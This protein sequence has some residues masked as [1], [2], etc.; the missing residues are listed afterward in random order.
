MEKLLLLKYFI[1][2]D[3]K[4]TYNTFKNESKTELLPKNLEQLI[5]DFPS[6]SLDNFE[7][8]LQNYELSDVLYPKVVK[9]LFLFFIVKTKLANNNPKKLNSKLL[10]LRQFIHGKY[11]ALLLEFHAELPVFSESVKKNFFKNKADWLSEDLLKRRFVQKLVKAHFRDSILA[12]LGMKDLFYLRKVF[13]QNTDCLVTRRKHSEIDK[14]ISSLTPTPI[15]EEVGC[16]TGFEGDVD[17]VLFE[18]QTEKLFVC[19][20]WTGV[21]VFSFAA[22]LQHLRSGG[23]SDINELVHSNK[24]VQFYWSAFDSTDFEL[25]CQAYNVSGN[26]D[27]LQVFTEP[28]FDKKMKEFKTQRNSQNTFVVPYILGKRHDFVLSKVSERAN[29]LG[30][31]TQDRELFVLFK[32]RKESGYFPALRK[33]YVENFCFYGENVLLLLTLQGDVLQ[34]HLETGKFWKVFANRKNA[35]AVMDFDSERNE[36]ILLERTGLLEIWEVGEVPD[37]WKLLFKR[38]VKAHQSD[39][40]LINARFHKVD[41]Q[42]LLLMNTGTTYSENFSLDSKQ[43]QDT[44]LL[45]W[46]VDSTTVVGEFRGHRQELFI[47]HST[48]DTEGKLVFCG[49]EDS[50]LFVWS[51]GSK[52]PVLI[53]E[54]HVGV[55]NACETFTFNKTRFLATV[56]DDRS[57][58][59][60]KYSFK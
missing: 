46:D 26:S 57:L 8:T 33:D 20:K 36:L 56:S 28:G 23:S 12:E 35:L 10:V 9:L 15:L 4:E 54:R 43:T 34:L 13:L 51:A 29:R 27:S 59:L 55:V 37:T 58:V 32:R 42:R 31:L 11:L 30:L 50:K 16:L 1:E 24:T 14:M 3:Y 18:P 53:Q 19:S 7:K 39:F 5:K 40:R 52:L 22:L 44:Q 25:L 41:G 47:L 6:F 49:D 60:W 38:S 17:H 45:L 21:L 48:L 2:N